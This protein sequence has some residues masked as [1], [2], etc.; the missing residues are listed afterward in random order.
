MLLTVPWADHG[1]LH[2]AE[3]VQIGRHGL[4]V[5]E[6][7]SNVVLRFGRTRPGSRLQA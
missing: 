3:A 4:P 7:A 1:G 5:Q 2:D 6:S